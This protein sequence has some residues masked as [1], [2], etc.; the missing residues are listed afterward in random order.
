MN[1]NERKQQ[2]LSFER[3]RELFFYDEQTGFFVRQIARGRSRA[4]E[5]AGRQH[6]NGYRYLKI[7]GFSFLEHRLAWLWMTS[8]WPAAMIDHRDGD[9]ANNAWSNLRPATRAQNRANSRT[10]TNSKG[11]SRERRCVSWRAEIRVNGKLIYLGS[12]KAK[13]DAASA[14]SAA[15]KLHF[16]EFARP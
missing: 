3:L 5:R 12:F 9:K 11:V 8:E 16:G 13:E 14:Y 6:P 10:K 15:A 4:G 1:P 7:D 2:S